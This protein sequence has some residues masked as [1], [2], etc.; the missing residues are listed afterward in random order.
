MNFLFP[1]WFCSRPLC[2]QILCCKFFAVM[3]TLPSLPLGKLVK[4]LLHTDVTRYLEFK[5]VDGSYVQKDGKINKIP[6]T[7]GEAASSPL[8]GWFE[9]YRFKDFLTFVAQYD[10]NNPKTHQG[11]SPDTP[12]MTM[13]KKYNLDASTMDMVGHSLALYP[14][15]SWKTEPAKNVIERGTSSHSP[16]LPSLPLFVP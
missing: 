8:L 2:H 6:S 5:S 14:D 10:V 15:E 16:S 9:A 3:I 12:T 1:T 4:M 13:M 11:V 7:P